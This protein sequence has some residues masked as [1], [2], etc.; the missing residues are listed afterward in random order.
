MTASLPPFRGWPPAAIELMES[1]ALKTAPRRYPADHPRI[2]YLRLGH[3]A[4]GIQHPVRRWLHAG[5]ARD[6]ITG[7]WR[8]LDPLLR[9]VADATR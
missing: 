1:G 4:A 2:G 6:R 9:W 7:P 3:L 8:A 5:A